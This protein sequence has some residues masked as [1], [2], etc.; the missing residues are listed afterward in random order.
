METN[1]EGSINVDM[2]TDFE[3]NI[4]VNIQEN[5]EV[6]IEALKLELPPVTSFVSFSLF[7][8]IGLKKKMK[9]QVKGQ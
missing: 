8:Q 2:Q 4:E 3:A 6:N 5:F 7:S 9:T 1:I